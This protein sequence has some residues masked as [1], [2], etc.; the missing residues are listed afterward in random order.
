MK[1]IF[2]LPKIA[3]M[4]FMALMLLLIDL[5][6]DREHIVYL[7]YIYGNISAFFYNKL[8]YTK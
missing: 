5:Y 4:L 8:F 7:T 2:S 6:I 1:N 3:F